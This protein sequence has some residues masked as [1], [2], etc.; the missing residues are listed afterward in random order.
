[1]GAEIS[2][3][4]WMLNHRL[5]LLLL[6]QH[7]PNTKQQ[8]TCT[9]TTNLIDAVQTN[10]PPSS[11]S[12]RMPIAPVSRRSR[13]SPVLIFHLGWTGRTDCLSSL[14]ILQSCS[15]AL[16]GIKIL[17]CLIW[18]M[19]CGVDHLALCS[20]RDS[21]PSWFVVL[22]FYGTFIERP[23]DYLVTRLPEKKASSC[24]PDRGKWN[25]GTQLNLM[26]QSIFVDIFVLAMQ[27]STW[28][29]RFSTETW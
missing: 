23:G 27:S 15:G 26:I 13:F 5:H 17:L 18:L 24:G 21:F 7:Y 11:I 29:P 14:S 3:T 22:R 10:S 8:N 20:S 4:F 25:H 6:H 12:P 28:V 19:A 9:S 16:W 1:M 2:T